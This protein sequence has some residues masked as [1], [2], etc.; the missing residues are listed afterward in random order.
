MAYGLAQEDTNQALRIRGA[1][2][3]DLADG[4]VGS[5]GRT[6]PSRRQV[7]V[8]EKGT[9]VLGNFCWAVVWFRAIEYG[10]VG[11]SLPAGDI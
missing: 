3:C 5:L 6:G 4:V 9:S 7:H 8:H 10:R 2:L 1:T 11:N